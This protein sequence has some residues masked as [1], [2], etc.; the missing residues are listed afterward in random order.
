MKKLKLIN[1]VTHRD[2]FCPNNYYKDDKIKH[3]L[4]ILIL[5]NILYIFLPYM[6]NMLKA[7]KKY[8]IHPNVDEM[9]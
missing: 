6:K 9:E 7:K 8:L 1:K 3:L 2:D 5:D 4:L